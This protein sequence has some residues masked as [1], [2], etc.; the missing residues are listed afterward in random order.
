MLK[1]FLIL[2]TLKHANSVYGQFMTGH[3]FGG[4]YTN[5]NQYPHSVFLDVNSKISC[6]CGGSILTQKVVLSAA[7]CFDD[8]LGRKRDSVVVRYGASALAQMSQ[9]R[10]RYYRLHDYYKEVTMYGDIALLL[11]TVPIKLGN[12][13]KRVAIMVSPPREKLAYVSGWGSVDVS[14]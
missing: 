6:I 11:C 10:M 12:A 13:V 8:Y 5:I 3:V 9:T 14:R 1:E 4:G 7:H 2:I